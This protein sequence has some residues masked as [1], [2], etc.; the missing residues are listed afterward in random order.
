MQVARSKQFDKQYKKLAAKIQKQFTVRLKLFLEDR[1]YYLLQVHSLSGKYKGLWSFNVN[2]DVRVV[3]DDSYEG[4]LIL[5][6]IG[7][8]SQLY[9]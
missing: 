6:A 2:A 4:V 3:Y 9:G 1:D 8:H 5:I 7:T